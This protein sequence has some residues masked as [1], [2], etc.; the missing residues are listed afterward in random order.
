MRRLVR[1]L[2]VAVLATPVLA[3]GVVVAVVPPVV[4]VLPDVVATALGPAATALFRSVAALPPDSLAGR[5]FH[6]SYVPLVPAFGEHALAAH[7]VVLA[8]PWLLLATLVAL[9]GRRPRAL[10]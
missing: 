4:E 5:A 10:A 8:L 2:V 6:A 3:A 7:A 1:A 9:G